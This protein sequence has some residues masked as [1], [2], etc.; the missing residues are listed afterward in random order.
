LPD[1]E[2]SKHILGWMPT[3]DLQQGLQKMWNELTEN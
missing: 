2:N 1:I 3:V